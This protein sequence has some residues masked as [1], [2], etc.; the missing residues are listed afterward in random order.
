MQIY[1]ILE[2]ATINSNF[3]DDFFNRNDDTEPIKPHIMDKQIEKKYS[4]WQWRT[5]IVLM[6]GYALFYFVRK[7]FS[8]E[9]PALES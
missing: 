9:M 1:I 7:N 8:I 6:I 5:L 2:S 3:A 4:Y